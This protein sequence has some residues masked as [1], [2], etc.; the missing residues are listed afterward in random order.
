METPIQSHHH[1]TLCVGGAQE[2]YQF[3]VRTLGLRNVKKTLLY[4]GRIPI[5]HLYYGNAS[6]QESTLITCFPMKQ[7]GRLGRFGSGQVRSVNLAV[8]EGGLE[9]WQRRLADHGIEAS[10]SERYGARRLVLHHPCGIE[11]Q[12]VGVRNDSR[13]P[14]NGSDVPAEAA[15]RGVYGVTVA[16]RDAIE[17]KD[18]MTGAMGFRNLGADGNH[19]LFGVQDGA[20]G[21]TVEIAYF[22]DLPQGSWGFGQGTVHHVAFKV[23]D[24]KMQ[25]DFKAYLEGLGYTDCSEPKNRGYFMSIYFRTPG[26]ALFEAAYSFDKGFAIDETYDNFGTVVHT[27]PWLTDRREEMLAQLEPLPFN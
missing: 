26:G 14:W 13:Q 8:P 23:Q 20:P 19:T 5:Y 24:D 4:D 3:H 25:A 12:M 27:P 7:D 2:D 1:L 11:Y 9:Y 15:I 10:P 17:M 22:P 16:V 21:K 18:F 6:G